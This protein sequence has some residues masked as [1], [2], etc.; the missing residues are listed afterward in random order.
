MN[1]FFSA[2][3]SSLATGV[4]AV[5]GALVLLTTGQASAQPVPANVAVP[6]YTPPAF[7]QGV[8][9]HWYAPRSA[10]FATQADTL[11]SAMAQ[12]CSADATAAAQALQRSRAQWQASAIAWDRLAAVAIGPLLQRR[13]QRQ[14]DFAPT[15]PELI[16]RAIRS[17]PANALAMERIGTPA[18]GFPALEWL[19]WSKPLALHSPHSP[20]CRYAQQ[21]AL[22]V[23]D[24]A[25]ALARAFDEL[26]ARNWLADEEAAAS[27]M[28]EM[29][30]Q[31]VGGLERL[32]WAQMEKPLHSARQASQGGHNGHGAPVFAR[33]TSGTTA[34][35]WAA[36]WDGIR[37]LAVA[38]EQQPPEPGKGLVAL[39]TYL[40][41]RGLSPLAGKLLAAVQQVQQAL[42]AAMPSAT[43]ADGAGLLIATKSLGKLKRLVEAEVAPALEVN[44]GFSDA[45][46]D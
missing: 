10:E 4:K 11:A 38:L 22:E 30:N 23:S 15:R 46:G 12:L 14:I 40:R 35:S 24:E 16:A 27:A 41:G 18:K 42:P 39:E 32:R 2:V 5:I 6:F 1:E 44:I 21:L 7:M 13:S 34:Q 43:P 9:R 29:V 3:R 20:A 8:H 28:S 31:W 33:S 19:L 37:S 25:K 26:A 36:Q 45:D 17:A